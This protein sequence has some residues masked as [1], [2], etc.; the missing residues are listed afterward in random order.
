M[1]KKESLLNKLSN[2]LDNL[3]EDNVI[4]ANLILLAAS[5]ISLNPIAIGLNT[6][7]L[8][9]NKLSSTKSLIKSYEKKINKIESV[10][11][12]LKLLPEEEHDEEVINTIK[13]LH[14]TKALYEKRILKLK[15]EKV[16]VTKKTLKK[17]AVKLNK[18]LL[19]KNRQISK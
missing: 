12:S 15:Q 14:L 3:N 16:K 1:S 13:D 8:A 9:L 17:S 4:K 10:I 7:G 6:A 11:E 19:K 2:K 5:L 18:P